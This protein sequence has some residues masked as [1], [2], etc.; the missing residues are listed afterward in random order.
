MPADGDGAVGGGGLPCLP[1]GTKPAS[2]GHVRLVPSPVC[3]ECD[4]F[5]GYRHYCPECRRNA[6]PP[7][8]PYPVPR[9]P[10]VP[11]PEPAGERKRRWWRADWSLLEV[12]VACW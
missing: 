2:H 3:V 4:R 10:P 8:I 1:A 6:C 5:T 9:P 11:P 7:R 12:F